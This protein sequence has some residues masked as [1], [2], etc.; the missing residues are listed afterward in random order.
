MLTR[1][2]RFINASRATKRSSNPAICG[3][4]AS[5]ER[6]AVAM[7]RAYRAFLRRSL[8]RL[9]RPYISG[10]EEAVVRPEI[11]PPGLL[12]ELGRIPTAP[13]LGSRRY[14]HMHTRHPEEA[15]Q[16]VLHR[17]AQADILSPSG[18]SE[19][20]SGVGQ[21]RQRGEGGSAADEHG[22][23]RHGG[24]VIDRPDTRPAKAW[25]G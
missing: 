18:H 1:A 9:Y 15:R 17:F 25:A 20:G 22:N 10:V 14:P 6:C 8:T 2:R 12:Q 7:C 3:K 5:V 11:R 21:G 19:G 4:K 13:A 23:R 24:C 16:R